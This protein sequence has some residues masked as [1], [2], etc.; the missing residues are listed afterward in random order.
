MW[1]KLSRERNSLEEYCCVSWSPKNVDSQASGKSGSR[2]APWTSKARLFRSSQAIDQTQ[3]PVGATLCASY[4]V[5]VLERK[6]LIGWL[7]SD[8]PPGSNQLWPEG[9]VMENKYGCQV[10]SSGQNG[11][12]RGGPVFWHC[13]KLPHLLCGLFPLLSMP[14]DLPALTTI[15]SSSFLHLPHCRPY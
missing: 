5:Q 15:T 13:R 10:L 4:L 9:G 1:V 7:V 2:T 3:H 11:H 14:R 12:L 8:V 6:N